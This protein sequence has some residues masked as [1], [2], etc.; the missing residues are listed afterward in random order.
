[1][2]TKCSI[3]YGPRKDGPEN[4]QDVDFHLFYE[5]FDNENV[6]LKI[7]GADLEL[8]NGYA[9]ISIPGKL[10][11]HLV[12]RGEL[13]SADGDDFDNMPSKEEQEKR[14][15]EGIEST[16]NWLASLRLKKENDPQ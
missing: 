6:Y 2:S 13:K 5:C 9:T 1:M 15:S 16:T 10:W 14:F 11:N 4:L 7:R 12:R 8:S 3:D